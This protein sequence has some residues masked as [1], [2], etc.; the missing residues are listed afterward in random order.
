VLVKYS[1]LTL[2]AATGLASWAFA[3]QGG[4]APDA[5][6]PFVAAVTQRGFTVTGTVVSSRDGSLVLKIDDHGHRI[7]F[8][9]AASVS[10]AELRPGSRVSVH[11]HPAGATGQVVDAIEAS[12]PRR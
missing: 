11:Y 2:L 1:A 3:A 10:A 12:P 6:S 5:R 8:S 7:P 9:L 4:P